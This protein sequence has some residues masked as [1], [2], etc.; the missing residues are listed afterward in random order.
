MKWFFVV[1]IISSVLKSTLSDSN[2]A[3]PAFSCIVFA[4]HIS[5]H[6]FTFHLF[7][8]LYLNCLSYRQY[9]GVF[10]FNLVSPKFLCLL[11][12]VCNTFTSNIIM[13]V[14]GC[15]FT[16][17]LFFFSFVLSIFLF[18]HFYSFLAFF[19]VRYFLVL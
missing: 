9:I 8:F 12:G 15:K 5:L 4:L 13:D 11:I 16:I 2:I 7:V 17:L 18:L 10:F 6:P 1:L 14:V 19:G 3:L